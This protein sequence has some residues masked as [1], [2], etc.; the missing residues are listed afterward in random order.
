MTTSL[1]ANLPAGYDP[2]QGIRGLRIHDAQPISVRSMTALVSADRAPNDFSAGHV[3]A[4][5]VKLRVF[6][7]GHWWFSAHL[8]DTSVLA[9]DNYAVGFSFEQQGFAGGKSGELGANSTSTPQHIH[10]AIQGR[11]ERLQRNFFQ[12][13]AGGL[14][15]RLH[16][17]TDA[18]GV[19]NDLGDDLKWLGKQIEFAFS[20][21]S[22]DQGPNPPDDTNFYDGNGA[23]TDGG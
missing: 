6:G 7:D 23:P 1:K 11:D 21:D 15:F 17:S 13:L 18:T 8:D 19:F 10:F 20:A 22:G 3:Y 14:K 12:I 9:G 16:Q 5:Q 4:S 2:R